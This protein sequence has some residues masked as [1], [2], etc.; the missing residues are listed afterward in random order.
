MKG[1]QN[2]MDSS[3]K[4]QDLVL[5]IGE[6]DIRSETFSARFSS[7]GRCLVSIWTGKTCPLSGRSQSAVSN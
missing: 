2:Q 6:L 7:I 1:E 4:G 5:G 3:T